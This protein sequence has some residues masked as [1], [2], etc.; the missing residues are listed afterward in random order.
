MARLRGCVQGG[1]LVQ[2]TCY[3][4]LGCFPVRGRV[5]RAVLHR[6]QVQHCV[7]QQQPLIEHQHS[8]TGEPRTRGSGHPTNILH[9]PPRIR[10][11]GVSLCCFWPD[12]HLPVVRAPFSSLFPVPKAMIWQQRAAQ[13]ATQQGPPHR[14]LHTSKC[15][16]FVAAPSHL[17]TSRGLVAA[18]AG[19]GSSR[20][21]SSVAT[22]AAA[23]SKDATGLSSLRF[24]KPEDGEMAQLMSEW[25]R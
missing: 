10:T 3:V 12:W 2:V 5:C 14:Q 15:V 9:S 8:T 16:G 17:S 21:R 18:R 20:A 1:V 7:A 13:S 4:P 23:Y 22:A 11:G 24:A 19:G 6:Q 25:E